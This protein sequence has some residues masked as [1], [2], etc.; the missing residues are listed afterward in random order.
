MRDPFPQ[1]AAQ[2]AGTAGLVENGDLDTSELSSEVRSR[3]Q[4]V[5]LEKPIVRFE[6][7]RPSKFGT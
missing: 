5:Q 6:N 7:T 2:S 4:R 1:C 3:P